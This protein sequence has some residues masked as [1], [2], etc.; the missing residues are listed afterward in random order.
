[1]WKDNR[2]VD[3]YFVSKKYKLPNKFCSVPLYRSTLYVEY[4]KFKEWNL[5]EKITAKKSEKYVDC[6]K[7]QL[8]FSK[9]LKDHKDVNV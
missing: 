3:F 7:P 1:M 2:T 6:F 4:N 9:Y 8:L 5:S